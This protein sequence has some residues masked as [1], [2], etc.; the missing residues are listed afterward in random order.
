M[1]LIWIIAANI[2]FTQ[3]LACACV[4]LVGCTVVILPLV[5][6]NLAFLCLAWKCGVLDKLYDIEIVQKLSNAAWVGTMTVYALLCADWCAYILPIYIFTSITARFYRTAR[7][8]RA[9]RY[10]PK[11][12]RSR[13]LKD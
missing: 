12:I 1:R 4:V 11:T 6:V 8:I 7:L 2:F 13:Y 9:N 10:C 3:L 5:L